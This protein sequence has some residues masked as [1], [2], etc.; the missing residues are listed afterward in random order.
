MGGLTLSAS[1]ALTN[2][3]AEGEFRRFESGGPDASTSM[4]TSATEWHIWHE[5]QV[6]Q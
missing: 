3:A 6:L 4:L 5:T 1:V 2:M